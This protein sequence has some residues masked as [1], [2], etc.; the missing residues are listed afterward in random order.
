MS[1]I[2]NFDYY[3]NCCGNIPYENKAEW[4]AFFNQIAD[5]IVQDLKPKRV[6][7]AGCAMGYLV[8]AL[9]DRGVEAYGID[10]SEYAI[11]KVRED[12][13]PYCFIG[14][15]TDALPDKMPNKYDLVITIEVLEHLHAEEGEKAIHNLCALSDNILFSSTP[16][17][18]NELTH[19]NVQQQEYWARIFAK[20]GFLHE[21]NYH[22]SY[23]TPYASYFVK[24]KDWLREVEDYERIISRESKFSCTKKQWKNII[25]FDDG[26]G[27]SK[28][29]CQSIVCGENEL[30]P[31]YCHI[32]LPR[33]CNSIRFEPVKGTG[34][35]IWDLQAKTEKNV[36]Q[37]KDCNGIEIGDVY[38][39]NP[40]NPVIYIDDLNASTQIDISCKIIPLNGIGWMK[41]VNA[42]DDLQKK[43]ETLK[44]ENDEY[45]EKCNSLQ[46]SLT[47]ISRQ[48]E[49]ANSQLFQERR[50]A[51]QIL[52]SYQTISSSTLWKMTKPVR[53]VLDLTKSH[54]IYPARKTISSL[55]NNGIKVTVKKVHSKLSGRPAQSVQS[56]SGET[57]SVSSGQKITNDPVDEIKTVLVNESIR[58]INLVTD[59]IDSSSLLGGVATALIVASVFANK[60]DYELRIITRK[61]DTNPDNYQNLMKISGVEPARKLSFYSD[62][63]RCNHPVDYR[64]EISPDDVFL[65]TSW[66][67]A[68]AIKNTSIRKRFFY[69]IQEVETFFYNYGPERMLCEQVMED[70]NI[71]F[72]INSHY[73]FDYF[74]TNNPN[75]VKN[76]VFFEPAFP[77]KLYNRKFFAK[78]DKYKLFFYSRPHNPRNLYAVGV[79]YLQ[80]AVDRGIIDTDEWDIYCVGQDAPVIHFS[81]GKN[82]INVGQLTWTEYSQFLSDVDLGLCLMY[83]PHPSYPPFDVASSGGVVLTNKFLNKQSFEMCKNII[84]AD[85]DEESFMKG[86]KEAIALA[87]DIETRKNNFENSSIPRDW[88]Q[89]LEKTVDFMGDACKH[90][91]H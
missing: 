26:S 79:K 17:D 13:K 48:F 61:T 52:H 60:Y 21:L 58:R 47:D 1:E 86:F 25:S 11:S 5:R 8:A 2:Y 73:L 23:I 84:A 67:S 3:H 43:Y 31:F 34:C 74:S 75:I 62:F 33:N 46:E 59:T 50:N 22:P 82:S 6:L 83:T 7:D 40:D 63:D 54:L 57:I 42:L 77:V 72:I 81:T 9:R 64:M 28:T 78:K 44:S 37:V 29:P 88:N 27:F 18:F 91:S 56:Y 38:V 30:N 24:N 69:I 76:G 71:D 90:V 41:V 49:E 70:K 10:V 4:E 35:L 53:V 45:Y 80:A 55:K 15:I 19:V 89:T 87:K 32:N 12:V 85:L 66:W 16:S 65:A 68:E 51:S 36:A 14:S 39:F 20:N